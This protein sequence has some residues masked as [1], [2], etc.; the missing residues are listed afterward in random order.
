MRIEKHGNAIA[1]I[2]KRNSERPTY[3]FNIGFV[4]KAGSVKIDFEPGK[5]DIEWKTHKPINQTRA[6]KP[7]ID[8]QPG[9]VIIGMKQYQSLKIDFVNLK[10]VG[11]NFEQEI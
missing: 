9:N 1:N 4:P 6:Q 5:V 3:D 10:Y 11:F 2:S 8:Y 7:I